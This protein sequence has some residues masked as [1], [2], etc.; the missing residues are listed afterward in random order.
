MHKLS[1]A[2]LTLFLGFNLALTAQGPSPKKQKPTKGLQV[3]DTAKDFELLNV[4]GSNYSLASMEDA[5]GYIVVF[6][7]NVCPFALMY[8]DRLI[9]LHNTMAPKGYPV[10]AINANDP[11]VEPGDSFEGMQ[12]KSK[13]KAF[14][15][16]YLRDEDQSIYPQFGATKTPHVFLLDK[17]LKVQYIGAIDDNARSVEDVEVKYVENAIGALE[18]GESP[19]PSFTKAI[20]CSIKTKN[21]GGGKKGKGGRRGPPSP[22]KVLEMMDKDNDGKVSTAEASGRLTD[23]FKNLDTDSNGFLTKEELSAMKKRGPRRPNN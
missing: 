5:K 13:E 19:N 16:V 18:N 12:E 11:D 7:S 8:E 10:V 17:D 9:E 4:D 15:F 1:I 6:T 21:G 14:P 20:G 22:D 3:G 23:D 2:L